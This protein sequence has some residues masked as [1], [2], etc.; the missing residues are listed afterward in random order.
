[1]SERAAR[2][3]S[4]D[5]VRGLVMALMALD[6]TR[7]F[8]GD[9]S[10]RPTD[11]AHASAA[12]FFTRWITHFC[13]P[14]FVL[15]AGVSAWLHEQKLGDGRAASRFLLTRGL[16]LIV[17]E[18]TVVR[19]GWSLAVWQPRVTLQVIWALGC[20]MIALAALRALP[21]WLV[22]T[23]GL[24]LCAG[25]NALDSL[26]WGSPLW[27]I[28]H[29]SRRFT[30]G[31]V[32]VFV[33]YPLLPWIGLMALG[34]ALGPVFK[35]PEEEQRK[36]LLSLGAASALA[37]VLVRGA[38]VYGDLAP[39]A[40]QPR[41]GFTALAWLNCTKYP[42]SFAYLLMTLGPVLMALA[43]WTA[44]ESPVGD[45]LAKFGRV[46]LFFYVVH[47]PLLQLS[48]GAYLIARGG[49]AAI[50]AAVTSGRGTGLSLAGVYL[51]WALVLLALY[52]A[53]RWFAG[54]KERRTDWW[55][56]YL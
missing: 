56:S 37:F 45:R 13:A 24:I 22:A 47:L 33:L 8:F 30:V 42:P 48:A 49:V 18:L 40:S 17:L 41:A 35:K 51:V 26:Q 20:S 5:R 54:V 12:L 4:L 21:R 1:M 7:D 55:L 10:V 27:A 38:N 46:P 31:P 14:T 34:Y 36:T 32:R 52:P 3:S 16:W 6:H 39:W 15:L 29:V 9:W 50:Q 11:L 23:V 2:Q 25:H 43:L 19:A 28:L 44:K 53:C